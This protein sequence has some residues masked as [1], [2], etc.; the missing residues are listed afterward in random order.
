MTTNTFATQRWVPTTWLTKL[1]LLFA[2]GISV[3][4]AWA[5]DVT[6]KYFPA[7]PNPPRLVNDFAGILQPAEVEALE[8]KLVRFA[9][10]TT[11]QFSVITVPT[12]HEYEVGDY[13]LQ[14][15]RRWGIGK[16]D[17]NNGLILLI[18]PNERRMTF[19]VGYGLEGPLPDMM[20]NRIIKNTMAPHFRQGDY[21]GGIDAAVDEAIARTKGEYTAPPKKRRR[22]SPLS[23]VITILFMIVLFII[24]FVIMIIKRGGGGGG[25]GGGGGGSFRDFSRGAGPFIFGT[26]LG[27]GFGR[28]G[29]GG[30]GGGFGGGGGGGFGGFG[31]GS[32]GGGGSSG[33]W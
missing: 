9:D 15:G 17:R 31:G 33:G 1:L 4:T 19:Q 7:K 5:Q 29:F 24:V 16:K 18:A 26:G 10:S 6:D 2:M 11:N 13:A 20:T 30:G 25:F 28:G 14:L 23:T 12:L 8:Q 27:G 32:F 22:G 3:S 21:Y